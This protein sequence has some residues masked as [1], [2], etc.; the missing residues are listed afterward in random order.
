M[1][2][3][4][5]PRVMRVFVNS[6]TSSDVVFF[7]AQFTVGL[8]WCSEVAGALSR[9]LFSPTTSWLS[10]RRPLHLVGFPTEGSKQAALPAYDHG[11]IRRSCKM[12][13]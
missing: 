10:H 7:G 9:T 13:R 3:T 8:V 12:Y 2:A 5:P 11:S 6:T 4:T 1:V